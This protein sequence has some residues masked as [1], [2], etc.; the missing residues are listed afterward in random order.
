MS[1]PARLTPA[2]VR[3]QPASTRCPLQ[4]SGTAR[5]A[6]SVLRRG[7]PPRFSAR[8]RSDAPLCLGVLRRR[9]PRHVHS[10]RRAALHGRC[11]LLGQVASCPRCPAARSP[12]GLFA[13]AGTG[14]AHRLASRGSGR[15]ARDRASARECRRDVRCSGLCSSTSGEQSRPGQRGRRARESPRRLRSSRT[16]ADRSQRRLPL[17][18]QRR[19]PHHR[20]PGSSS[21]GNTLVTMCS[22]TSRQPGPASPPSL[23][24]P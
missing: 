7:L 17:H 8:G 6:S 9:L 12:N 10:A 16:P 1:R 18:L 15:S 20:V 2:G 24:T 23:P 13:H 4:R 5:D 19:Q 21:T 11:D 3:R 22:A 14:A